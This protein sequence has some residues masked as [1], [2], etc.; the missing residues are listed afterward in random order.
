MTVRERK[1]M[2]TEHPRGA[3]WGGTR[4]DNTTTTQSSTGR[5]NVLW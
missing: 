4:H 5:H 3:G 1:D 2:T